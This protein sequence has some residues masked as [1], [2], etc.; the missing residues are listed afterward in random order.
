MGIMNYK[1]FNTSLEA[2]KFY[3]DM[4]N[5]NNGNVIIKHGFGNKQR[6]YW[7]PKE[8]IKQA[9]DFNPTYTK[10]TAERILR[11]T[12]WNANINVTNALD[13]QKFLTDTKLQEDYESIVNAS[14][15]MYRHHELK[16]PEDIY[17]F[18]DY[19]EKYTDK[20]KELAESLLDDNDYD[21]KYEDS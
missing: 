17:A 5:Q 1:T 16:T 20:M 21:A 18:I 8:E 2:M 10:E 7:K 15:I 13:L 12:A 3:N 14:R 6:V 11:D 19:T 9:H 4:F